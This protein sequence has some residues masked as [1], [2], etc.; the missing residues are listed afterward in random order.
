[1]GVLTNLAK[2]TTMGFDNLATMN[3]G[4]QLAQAQATMDGLIAQN[5]LRTEAAGPGGAGS[6]LVAATATVTQLASTGV[7]VNDGVQVAL[8]LLV[9]LPAGVPVP[10]TTTTVVPMALLPQVHPGA[11]VGVRVDPAAPS[12]VLLDL[13]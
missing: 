11:T 7:M 3:V 8:G 10:V 5:Q 12:R 2:L 1:M 4:A 13:R 6:A 9:L